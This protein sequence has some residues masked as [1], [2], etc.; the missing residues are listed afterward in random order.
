[1]RSSVNAA[2]RAPHFQKPQEKISQYK[3]VYLAP[4]PFCGTGMFTARL[5]L[6][7]SI[8]LSVHDQS[9]IAGAKPYAQMMREGFTYSDIFQIDHDLF[10]PP[11]G[12]L[13][14][15]TNHSCDPSCGLRVHSA[16]FDMIA[17]RDLVAGDE[18]TYDYSTHQEH[19]E[20]E[21]ICLCG[22]ASCRGVVRSFSTLPPTLRRRYLAL[23]VVAK[24]IVGSA[25]RASS[26]C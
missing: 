22:A 15:F 12:G 23:G 3:H 25:E 26:R 4:T 14:D 24:F 17:L 6:A 8:V 7:G 2:E 10:I 21:I 1:M 9:Y 20:G 5:M 11:Y 19:P 13:D 18:L 16:G